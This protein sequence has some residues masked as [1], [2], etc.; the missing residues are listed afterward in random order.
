MEG[1]TDV[2]YLLDGLNTAQRKAV[3]HNTGPAL[4][5]AGAGTGKTKVITNR[6]AYLI[7]SGRAKPEEILALT[8]T[9]KAAQEMQDRVDELLPYGVVETHIMTFHALG[10]LL[11]RD[12]ALDMQINLRSR[13]A[14]PVQ[15]HILMHDV[16]ESLDGLEYFRPAHNPAMYTE[17]LLRYISRLKDEGINPVSL[18]DQINALDPKLDESLEPAKYLEIAHVYEAY[19]DKK[20]Q[21]GFIDFGDQL[22]MPYDLLS[23]KHQILS[24]IQEGYKFILVDEFQDTNTIQAKL[25]YLLSKKHQNLMVVGD[26]DQSIYR[27]RGAELDNILT[28]QDS[29]PK[30][31][32]IVLLD[33]YRSTQQIIDASYELIQ[34]NNP[35][36]LEAK[37]GINKRLRAQDEGRET[38]IIELS[39]IRAEIE[40]V[41][42]LVADGIEQ[43]GSSE[44]AVLTRNNQQV[45][46]IIR[47][48][49]QKALPVATRVAR[50]LLLQPVVRQ[51][52]DFLCVLHDQDDSAALY[53]YLISPKIAADTTMV[54]SLSAEAKRMNLSLLKMI[55]QSQDSTSYIRAQ[56]DALVTYRKRVQ[57]VS[58][59]E[60]LYMFIT[61]DQ[62]LERLVARAEEDAGAAHE[63]QSLARFFSLIAELE[64]VEGMQHSHDVWLHIREMYDLEI[65]SDPDEADHSEGVQV[66]TAH[67]AKGLEFKRVILFDVVDG[68]FPATRKGETL[69]LPQQLANKDTGSIAQLH[70]SEER[71]LFYVAITRAK[72]ELFVTYSRNHGGKR[73]KKPSRFLL[74]AFNH[75]LGAQTT[76]NTGLSTSVIHQFQARL[77]L[78]ERPAY[79]QTDGWL[80]L[81]PNQI[82]DYL[83]NPQ[84]FYVRHVLRFPEKQSHHMVYGT[85]I[86]AA[87]EVYFRQRMLKQPVG[88]KALIDVLHDSWSHNGFVSLRHE[89][90]RMAAAEQTLRR[91]WK[92]FEA[93]DLAIIDVERAF[94]VELD[95]FKL[96]IRGRYDLILAEGD[97]VEIRDFKT[98]A[99]TDQRVAANRVRDSVPMQIYALAWGL[100]HEAPVKHIALHFVDSGVLAKRDKLNHVRTRTQIK[101]VVEGIRAEQYPRKGILTN[102]EMEGLA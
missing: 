101:E 1:K 45:G 2:Q 76:K 29:F 96:R 69:Y 56:I 63:I 81:S 41:V 62:Y 48:L 100:E 91:L 85:S 65:L 77:P 87:L 52:V 98:S 16:L 59:G 64:A 95:E 13:L 40:R 83:T 60:L 21:Q 27:F 97:G 15:Q 44:V 82:Q 36:R 28:F 32:Q 70:L 79:P 14:S 19:E 25:L 68:T 22:M 57:E 78:G 89:E 8:F 7:Q 86:H 90:E 93:E 3:L 42:E 43:H 55:E 31:K 37:L 67:R 17:L 92:E 72:Q 94:Q 26:D 99:V 23:K 33:N 38:S 58:V 49:Q 10:G 39:D 24:H 5:I 74:E 30:A 47:A 71:R 11:M 53:R 20:H 61:S 4:V 34:H 84:Y 6:I 18:R 35:L 12:Y 50:N 80:T 46:S 54:I 73:M 75:D 9:D 102:L 51:C 88:I 66:L